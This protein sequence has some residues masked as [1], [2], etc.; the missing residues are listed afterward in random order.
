MA[1][2]SARRRASVASLSSH[3]LSSARRLSVASVSSVK[4]PSVKSAPAGS[5]SEGQRAVV[6]H[7]PTIGES[8][9]W[10]EILVEEDETETTTPVPKEETA[11]TTAETSSTPIRVERSASP[12]SSGT[13]P[14]R[15]RRA[16]T[17]GDH[18]T[19]AIVQNNM[20]LGLGD[21][22]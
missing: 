18:K 3:R 19:C 10:H 5:P 17:I 22:M 4:A 14:Y 21:I 7:K 12:S 13:Q 9:S 6:V 2:R 20:K 11:T 15:R 1:G 8:A 16:V